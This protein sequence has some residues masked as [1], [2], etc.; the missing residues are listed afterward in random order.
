[1]PQPDLSPILKEKSNYRFRT[2]YK[3]LI[4]QMVTILF[5]ILAPFLFNLTGLEAQIQHFDYEWVVRPH[6]RAGFM[7]CLSP[8]NI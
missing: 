1:M 2:S 5:E 7:F 6:R 4:K 8:N 3:T